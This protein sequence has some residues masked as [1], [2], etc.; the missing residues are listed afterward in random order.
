MGVCR[1]TARSQGSDAITRRCPSISSRPKR[2][3]ATIRRIA[4]AMGRLRVDPALVQ[5]PKP[6][7]LRVFFSR[8]GRVLGPERDLLLALPDRVPEI[9]RNDLAEVVDPRLGALLRAAHGK[10]HCTPRLHQRGTPICLILEDFCPLKGLGGERCPG[11]ES[12]HRHC[13]FQS[14]ALPT[15]LPGPIANPLARD[16]GEDAA[17]TGWRG[18]CPPVPSRQSTG[19]RNCR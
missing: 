3:R 9:I 8:L 7:D 1:S 18:A 12:N 2:R 11:A 17:F 4:E 10:D 14:H 13:D 6:R 16:R 5:P 15:E 19:L